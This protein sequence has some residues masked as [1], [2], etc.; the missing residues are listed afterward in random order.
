MHNMQKKG[1]SASAAATLIALIAGFILLYLLF[2]PP[3]TR[4]ALLGNGGSETTPGTDLPAGII[5][6][7]VLTETPGRIDYLKF[8]E[9]E[10]PLPAVTLYTVKNAQER[11]ISDSIY[12]K[13]GVF[14]KS[15]KNITFA[16]EDLENSDN[17]VLNLNVVKSAGRLSIEL[18][19]NPIFDGVMQRGGSSTISLPKSMLKDENVLS[20]SVSEVGWKFWTTNEYELRGISI[21]FDLTDVSQQKSKNVFTVSDVEKFN[22]DTVSLKFYPDCVSDVGTLDIEVNGQ[23]IYSSIPDCGQINLLQF[24]AGLIE[25]GNNRVIFS[26]KKGR[27]FIDQILVKTVMKP[28]TYPVFYFDLPDTLFITQANPLEDDE[29]CGDIDGVCPNNCD[30]DVDK[31]CCLQESSNYWCDTEPESSDKRCAPVTTADDCSSCASGYENKKGNPPDKCEDKCGDDT[32]NYCPSGCSK[33]Y[34][35]D[36]CDKESDTNFWCDDAPSG[37]LKTCMSSIITEQCD[38]CAAG[39]KSDESDFK[40]PAKTTQTEDVLKSKYRIKLTLKFI[41]DNERK[42]AKAYVNGYQFYIDTTGETYTKYIDSYIE[43]GTNAIKIEPDQTTLDI[44]KMLVE[45]EY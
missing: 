40:C 30:R 12:V 10:H 22:L 39:W 13:N 20:F 1:Q 25:S 44:R 16:L 37:G 36:C 26:T 15:D 33:L 7:S 21:I 6:K 32:D 18:N 23:N 45:I 5:N 35:K 28:M 17:V 24:S 41:N 34:D 38:L 42:A 14:D 3:E 4:D 29:K 31:D 19:G 9:Y 2:L 8:K 43:S 27:Y 11:K